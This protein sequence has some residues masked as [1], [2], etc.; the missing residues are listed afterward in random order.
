LWVMVRIVVVY[1]QGWW[2]VCMERESVCV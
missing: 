1:V 2:T